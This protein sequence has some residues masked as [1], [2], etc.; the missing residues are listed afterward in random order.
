MLKMG[1]CLLQ[2]PVVG[3]DYSFSSIIP[4]NVSYLCKKNAFRGS[5]SRRPPLVHIPHLNTYLAVQIESVQD[6]ACHLNV[7]QD[8]T[9]TKMGRSLEVV[10]SGQAL[11]LEA[12][13]AIISGSVLDPG[14]N[15]VGDTSNVSPSSLPV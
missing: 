8:D 15:I 6:K 14:R 12:Q 5:T 4:R 11:L 10:S 13:L 2:R 7:N 9:V 3:C 1:D